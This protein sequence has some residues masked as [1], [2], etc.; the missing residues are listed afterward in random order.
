MLPYTAWPEAVLVHSK[1]AKPQTKTNPKLTCLLM[2]PL[3]NDH[4]REKELRLNAIA[5]ACLNA[6]DP[7]PEPVRIRRRQ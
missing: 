7:L 4:I 6:A 1:N 5:M 2:T 3:L